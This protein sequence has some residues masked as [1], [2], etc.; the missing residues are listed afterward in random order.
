M[1]WDMA[2]PVIHLCLHPSVTLILLHG[3]LCLLSEH[4][5]NLLPWCCHPNTFI[6]FFYEAPL[7]HYGLISFQSSSTNPNIMS[8][9][10]P[11]L[12]MQ[13]PWL[14][15][16]VTISIF[17][18][19]LALSIICHHTYAC[20]FNVCVPWS[21]SKAKTVHVCLLHSHVC[22]TYSCTCPRNNRWIASGLRIIGFLPDVRN[23][24][25]FYISV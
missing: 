1:A 5:N 16:L 7:P 18:L 20:V 19:F 23:S 21:S 25:K 14:K 6:P 12:Q 9:Y 24:S 2:P 10:L 11:W 15:M 8:H 17:F 13:V 4:T 3:A 22:L